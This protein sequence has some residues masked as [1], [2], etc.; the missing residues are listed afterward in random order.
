MFLTCVTKGN[1]IMSHDTINARAEGRAA[2]YG[3]WVAHPRAQYGGSSDNVVPGTWLVTAASLSISQ[4]GSGDWPSG[5]FEGSL[6]ADHAQDSGQRGQRITG[7]CEQQRSHAWR[8]CWASCL[9]IPVDRRQAWLSGKTRNAVKSASTMHLTACSPA[10]F[11]RP[12]RSWS[13]TRFAG[14]VQGL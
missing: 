2:Q 9:E 14:S 7:L 4:G 3:S 8:D 10:S 13:A 6:R 11:N 5:C 1:I 12:T